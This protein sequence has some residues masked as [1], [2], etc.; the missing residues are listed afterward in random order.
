MLGPPKPRRLD[1]PITTSLE[2]LVPRDNFYRHLEAKIDLAFVREWAQELYA[3]RG[4]PSI[5]PVVFFKMHP[6]QCPSRT[7]RPHRR[8]D[9]G[10]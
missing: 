10:R 7:H 2:V 9:P 4:R 6:R 3:E 5:D 1:T 8:H